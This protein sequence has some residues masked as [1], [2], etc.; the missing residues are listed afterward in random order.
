MAEDVM[1]GLVTVKCSNY[2]GFSVTGTQEFCENMYGD[3]EHQDEP[4]TRESE[5]WYEHVFSFW[6]LLIAAVIVAGVVSLVTGTPF[7]SIF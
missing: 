1:S 2:C 5:H 7:K 6:G 4:G 3:H